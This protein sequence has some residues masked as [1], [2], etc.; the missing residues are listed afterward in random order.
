MNWNTCD[1][2]QAC[3]QRLRENPYTLGP[4]E[5][6]VV[7]NGSADSSVAMVRT[8]FPDVYLI[9]NGMNESYARGT[10]QAVGAARGDLLLLLNPDVQVLPESLDALA[11]FL[12]DK[13]R[14]AVGA[15]LVYPDGRVQPSVRGFPRPVSVLYDLLGLSRLFKRS[16]VLGDYRQTFFEYNC[17]ACPAPQPM[18]SCFLIT[19]QAWEAVGPMD[20]RFPLYFNDVD[21]C[22]RAKAAGV[23]VWYTARSTVVHGWGGTTGRSETVRRVARWESH[24]ALLRYWN[25][26][27]RLSRPLF[28]L[29]SAIVTLRAW[30]T[31]GRW[32]ESLGRYGGETTPESLH[33]ELER[34]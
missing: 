28:A 11:S 6:V 12:H 23:G 27:E 26:H 25:K 17:A 29:L 34:T 24:R 15:K 16:R 21:W 4:Q 5:V 19:R 13:P 20:E 10:N 14:A 33:R 32:G 7:D 18:A 2:L 31:T 3:L 9:A 8:E 1:D 22:F 30:Q